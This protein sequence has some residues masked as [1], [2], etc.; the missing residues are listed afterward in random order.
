MLKTKIKFL[1]GRFR[2][3]L[4]III[5]GTILSF[6]LQLVHAWV[7]PPASPPTGNVGAPINTSS[8]SQVKLGAFG[9]GGLFKAYSDAIFSGNVG[10]GTATPGATLEVSNTAWSQDIIR[11]KNAVGTYALNNYTLTTPSSFLIKTGGYMKFSSGG[12]PVYFSAS[13][14]DDMLVN[15]DGHVGI[16]VNNPIRP[17]HVNGEI[18]LSRSDRVGF[19]NISDE[20]GNGGGDIYLR[21]LDRGGST[22]TDANVRIQGNLCLSG[23][24][25]CRNS[26]PAASATPNL[27]AVTDQ[28]QNTWHW[29]GSPLFQIMNNGRSN[30][31]FSFQDWMGNGTGGLGIYSDD[32]GQQLSLLKN[33]SLYYS[34]KVGIGTANPSNELGWG[35][36]LEVVGQ[37]KAARYVDDDPNYY[38]D[39]NTD[40]TINNL[41]IR[42]ILNYKYG[43]AGTGKF[44]TTNDNGDAYWGNVPSSAD[45]LQTV[46]DRGNTTWQWLGFT[47]FSDMNDGNYYV[48]PNGGSRMNYILGNRVDAEIF[49]DSNDNGYYVDPNGTS[50]MNWVNGNYFQAYGD[51]RAP[52]FRDTNNWDYY[53]DPNGTSVTSRIIVNHGFAL[54]GGSPGDVLVKKS[55]GWTEWKSPCAAVQNCAC[56]P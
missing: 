47:G 55:D 3:W 51:V 18:S 21:G 42:G 8:A 53:V 10:I 20:S 49:V 32:T 33:G 22:G 52:L 43:G 46:T 15:T 7:I 45:N 44:L 12:N 5:F 2:Y 40:S 4:G 38:L 36:A 16:G 39:M 6:S 29:I 9:V 28:G 17:L 19:I 34:G 23:G 41:G 50:S 54:G 25:D 14:A 56:V 37:V 30:G 1:S 48:D 31:W 35:G 24:V 27:Q 11:L 13:G 26:W